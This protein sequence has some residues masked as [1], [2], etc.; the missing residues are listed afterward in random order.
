[1]SNYSNPALSHGLPSTRVLADAIPGDRVRDA[2][3]IL[4]GAGLTALGGQISINVAHS[5]VPVTGQ[6]L[7]VVLAGSTLGMWR[8]AASQILF[9]V[10]GL[11][12]PIYA[13]GTSGGHVVWG[14]TGG[15]IFGFIVAAALVGWAAEHGGDRR[16][17]LAPLTFVLGQLAIF[18][19]ACHG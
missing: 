6:T 17:L 2:L 10:L 15:Y 5:P 19:S 14:A 11:F 9:L 4:G 8:G 7:G 16:W 18:G 13:A 12:L 1:M 3:L